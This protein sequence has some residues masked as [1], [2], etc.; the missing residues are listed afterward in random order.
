MFG[1]AD[2]AAVNWE[3]GGPAGGGAANSVPKSMVEA[4]WEG[5][6]DGGGCLSFLFYRGGLGGRKPE[7]PGWG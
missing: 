6:K 5:G 2:N 1:M 7:S 3:C 4:D